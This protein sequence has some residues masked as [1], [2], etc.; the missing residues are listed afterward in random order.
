MD[1]GGADWEHGVYANELE[2]ENIATE[3]FGGIKVLYQ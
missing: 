2:I 3:S 1:E